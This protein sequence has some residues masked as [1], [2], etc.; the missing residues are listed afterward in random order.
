M[1]LS[2]EIYNSLVVSSS[3]VNNIICNK[4]ENLGHRCASLK[5]AQV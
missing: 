1:Q 2:T 3:N 4:S 5:D